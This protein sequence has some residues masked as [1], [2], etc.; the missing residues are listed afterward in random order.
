[1]GGLQR[2]IDLF[3]GDIKPLRK[4]PRHHLPAHPGVQALVEELDRP[5]AGQHSPGRMGAGRL[6]KEGKHHV[7]HDVFGFLIG[8]TRVG[9]D[10]AA[11]GSFPAVEVQ[12]HLHQAALLPGFDEV[13]LILLRELGIGRVLGRD[14][15]LVREKQHRDALRLIFHIV[16][17]YS[18]LHLLFLLLVKCGLQRSCLH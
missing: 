3:L 8:G 13:L 1:M 17:N 2:Q 18:D 11:Q 16:S 5:H 6:T 4:L 12:R 15:L 10:G 14:N 7:A 9:Q